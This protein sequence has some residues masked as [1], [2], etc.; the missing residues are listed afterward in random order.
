MKAHGDDDVVIWGEGVLW[1]RRSGYIL[2]VQRD[3]RSFGYTS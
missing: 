2:K 1:I 3:D